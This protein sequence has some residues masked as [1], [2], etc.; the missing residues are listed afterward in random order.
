MGALN[1]LNICWMGSKEEHKQSRRFPE[2]TD[3][4]FLTQ[5]I[6]NVRM[7]AF[8]LDC[9]VTREEGIVNPSTDT[10]TLLSTSHNIFYF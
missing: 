5:V 6:E 3:D 2:N 4:N 1:H 7:R 8:L 9:I 10:E